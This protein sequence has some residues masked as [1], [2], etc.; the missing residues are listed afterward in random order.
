[1]IF[2]EVNKRKK[3]K[4]GSQS[5]YIFFCATA[6]PTLH[7][8]ISFRFPFAFNKL[9][10]FASEILLGNN[11]HMRRMET[12][13]NNIYPCSL[14]M[15]RRFCWPTK[16]SSTLTTRTHSTTSSWRTVSR[17]SWPVAQPRYCL[18][19]IVAPILPSATLLLYVA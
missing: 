5:L 16:A 10:L 6:S 15:C 12:Y 9:F 2:Y 17:K 14:D 13:L 19:S 18:F 1:M 8:C 7:A 11:V 3:K 4:A